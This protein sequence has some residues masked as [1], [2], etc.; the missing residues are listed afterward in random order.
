MSVVVVDSDAGNNLDTIVSEFLSLPMEFPAHSETAIYE[1]AILNDWGL[2]NYPQNFPDN[3]HLSAIGGAAHNASIS[4]W[5]FAEVASTGI[6]DIAE[7]GVVD[8][9]IDGEVAAGIEAG[10][11]DAPIVILEQTGPSINGAP[12]IQTF[13]VEMRQPWPLFTFATKLAPSPDW[14]VG[15]SSLPLYDIATGWED[16]FQT[17]LPLMDGG[18]KSAA[19]PMNGGPSTSPS[20][21]IN[22]VLYDPVTGTY[23][24]GERPSF[25]ARLAIIRKQ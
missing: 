6:V 19:T 25:V 2:E 22:F 7:F 3:A 18:T 24:T 17:T 21:P 1:V 8:A 12:G 20:D 15:M 23:I 4:F 9:F 5:E 11:V 13:N 10:F 14:F 16:N